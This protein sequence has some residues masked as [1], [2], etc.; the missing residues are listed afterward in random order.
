MSLSPVF[1]TII[2]ASDWP[3]TAIPCDITLRANH[4][5]PAHM[6][7]K[8]EFSYF[9]SG[10]E[11]YARAIFSP[12]G[13]CAI[14]YKQPRLPNGLPCRLHSDCVSSF[15]SYASVELEILSKRGT[16]YPVSAALVHLRPDMTVQSM[17][18]KMKVPSMKDKLTMEQ[19]FMTNVGVCQKAVKSTVTSVSYRRSDDKPLE[20]ANSEPIGT[21]HSFK[22]CPIPSE[23]E[24]DGLV[25]DPS[26]PARRFLIRQDAYRLLDV[27]SLRPVGAR[28]LD[29]QP[30]QRRT[31]TRTKRQWDLHAAEEE[32]KVRERMRLMD[33]QHLRDMTE[34]TS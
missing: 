6:F 22:Q 15:C 30:I 28:P 25:N 3:D 17:I 19:R 16:K 7:C 34:N 18:Q 8:R 32:D 4:G 29:A 5:C 1:L 33:A 10:R 11:R 31:L 9:P 23:Y 27:N 21:D 14:K 13:F 26:A 24:E 20:S 2:D 12:K